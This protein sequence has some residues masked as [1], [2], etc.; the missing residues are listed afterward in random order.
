[1]KSA[2]IL[3]AGALLVLGAGAAQAAP[4]PTTTNH[5]QCVSSSA[6]PDGAGGRSAVARD[7]GPCDGPG[8][9]LVCAQNGPAGTVVLDSRLNTVTIT[10]SGP[11]SLGSSLECTTSIPVTAG[12]TLS[13]TYT[14]G[15]GTA[16]CG[17]GVPRMF[18]VLAPDGGGAPITV[19]TFDNGTCDPSTGSVTFAQSGTVTTVGFVYDR[20]DLGS[21]TY[22]NATL[23][24]VPLNI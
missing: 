19:N 3:L 13:F 16:P 24:G 17:G 18:A 2:S 6:R 23:G 22:S 21:V 8:A 12:Q 15:A 9:Q 5:G 10:G 14:L 11:G 7:K 1:M 20:G 4:P